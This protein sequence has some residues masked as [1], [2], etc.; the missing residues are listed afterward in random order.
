MPPLTQALHNRHA[1]V[2]DTALGMRLGDASN[3]EACY[4]CHPGSVTKCLRGAMGN[5]GMQCQSCH[6]QMTDVGSNARR[7]WIDE[8]ACESCHTGTAVKFN[9]QIRQTNAFD[10]PGGAW[11]QPADRRFAVTTG[12]LYKIATGHGGVACEACHGS[13]HAEYPSSHVNDNLQIQKLQGHTGTLSECSACHGTLASGAIGPHGMHVI[14]ASWVSKHG[15][16]VESQGSGTCRDCHGGDLRGT[17]LSAA[18]TA[19]SFSIEGGTKSFTKGQQIG[20]YSCH[21]GPNP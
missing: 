8:P 5:A 15:D 19:R 16:L 6:G 21:N 12:S 10:H 11:R 17:V 18:L 7:G 3:R 9:G 4:R 2:W 1:T 13:T 20:C 14:G